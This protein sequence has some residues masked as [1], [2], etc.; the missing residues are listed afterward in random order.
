[1][2]NPGRAI[3]RTMPISARATGKVGGSEKKR[4]I[5]KI[6]PKMAAVS[7]M[8]SANMVARTI[9]GCTC[10]Y[11]LIASKLDCVVLPCPPLTPRAAT[12][13][14]AATAR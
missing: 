2:V 13:V 5:E 4:K 6:S 10:G 9:S 3:E 11:R 12:T 8:A 1:M 7:R 14:H